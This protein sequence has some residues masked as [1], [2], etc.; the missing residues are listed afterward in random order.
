MII[1][2][3]LQLLL[4]LFSVC[5]FVCLF[6]INQARKGRETMGGGSARQN[7]IAILVLVVCSYSKKKREEVEP[8]RGRI[9]CSTIGY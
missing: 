9:F 2:M 1:M 7:R 8:K 5:L 3:M 4:L 6:V